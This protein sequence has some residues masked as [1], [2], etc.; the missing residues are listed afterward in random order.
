MSSISSFLTFSVIS[1]FSAT[2]S[3]SSTYQAFHLPSSSTSPLYP[4]HSPSFHS[5]LLIFYFF[6]KRTPFQAFSFL[7]FVRFYEFIA[8]S[9]RSNT[10]ELCFYFYFTS[11]PT[12]RSPFLFL[13]SLSIHFCAPCYFFPLKHG[14]NL[15]S[16][17]S[18]LLST[19]LLLLSSSSSFPAF[20]SH[21]SLNTQHSRGDGVVTRAF[22]LGQGKARQETPPSLFIIQLRLK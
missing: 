21:G 22:P 2:S 20:S 4:F 15:Y 14:P 12:N 13:R 19:S 3:P 9:F 11:H 8:V 1:M 6:L 5:Y 16:Y 10:R 18:F 17:S 7:P